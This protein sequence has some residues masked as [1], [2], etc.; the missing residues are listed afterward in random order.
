MSMEECKLCGQDATPWFHINGHIC[1]DCYYRDRWISVKDKLPEVDNFGLEEGEG[2]SDNVLIIYSCKDDPS[3]IK[4]CRV[5]HFFISNEGS[6]WAL[7]EGLTWNHY[8]IDHSKLLDV[9]HWMPLP[10]PP[11]V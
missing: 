7:S 4:Y 2:I 1:Q 8:L 5:G 6:E 10:E 3:N 11:N 9:T